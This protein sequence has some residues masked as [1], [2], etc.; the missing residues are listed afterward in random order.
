MRRK[1]KLCS[2]NSKKSN[3][4]FIQKENPTHHESYFIICKNMQYEKIKKET[5]TM[6]TFSDKIILN[7]S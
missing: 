3:Q 1:E 2:K 7:N 5:K 6:K 4:I